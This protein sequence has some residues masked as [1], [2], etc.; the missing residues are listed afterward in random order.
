MRC[1]SEEDREE[2]TM[3]PPSP[4]PLVQRDGETPFASH[5][6][7]RGISEGFAGLLA[8]R[9]CAPTGMCSDAHVAYNLVRG[10]P[11]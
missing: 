4:P 11:K 5:G 7:A 8:V 2:M 9:A 10:A 1:D 3:P 6:V